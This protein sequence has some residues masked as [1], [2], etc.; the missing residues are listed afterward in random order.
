M[1]EELEKLKKDK[2]DYNDAIGIDYMGGWNEGL[3][4]GYEVGRKETI[5]ELEKNIIGTQCK[6]AEDGSVLDAESYLIKAEVF[7]KLKKEYGVE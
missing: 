6:E 3:E 2:P 4:K 7:N 1:S 5:K